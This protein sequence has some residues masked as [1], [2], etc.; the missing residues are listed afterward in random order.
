MRNRRKLF[1]NG[2]FNALVGAEG[3]DTKKWVLIAVVV[4]VGI[5]AAYRMIGSSS[6]S[7]ALGASGVPFL[8]LECDHVETYTLKEIMKSG[9]MGR[10]MKA[11]P[12]DCSKC[13]VK[14]AMEQAIRCPKC[15]TVYYCAPPE[16]AM[17]YEDIAC[18]CPKCGMTQAEAYKEIYHSKNKKKK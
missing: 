18:P 5:V 9:M 12:Q 15:Q 7:G 6:G 2:T 3:S 13:G 10:D 17:A 11:L 4:V 1:F 16:D 14:E 8:C